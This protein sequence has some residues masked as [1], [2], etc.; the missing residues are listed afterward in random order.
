MF[1][2]QAVTET[3]SKILTIDRDQKQHPRGREERKRERERERVGLFMVLRAPK[4]INRPQCLRHV[5]GEIMR[6]HDDQVSHD[7]NGS[8]GGCGDVY[9]FVQ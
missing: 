8:V 5:T 4:T 2:S 3:L 7:K 1:G 6:E 9:I